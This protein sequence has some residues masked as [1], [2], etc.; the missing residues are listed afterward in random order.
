MQSQR[1]VLLFI[2]IKLNFCCHIFRINL[3]KY[4]WEMK[5]L[6][7]NLLNRFIPHLVRSF[8]RKIDE[9]FCTP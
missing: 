8:K 5:F 2:N 7:L 4:I 6:E 3:E 1:S 9:E